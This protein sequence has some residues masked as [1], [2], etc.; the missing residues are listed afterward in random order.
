MSEYCIKLH[1]TFRV[2]PGHGTVVQIFI[3]AEL[4]RV[5]WEFASLAYM[6]LVCTWGRL[7]AVYFKAICAGCFRSMECLDCHEE[8]TSPWWTKVGAVSV[9]SVRAGL[10][11]GCLLSS[12]LFVVFMNRLDSQ[13]GGSSSVMRVLLGLVEVKIELSRKAK[14]SIY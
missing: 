8:W 10:C 1:I 13:I 12:T 5:L 14:L 9:F 7:M 2:R 6:C 4:I 11:Q 3:L